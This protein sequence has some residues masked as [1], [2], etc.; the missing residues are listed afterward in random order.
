MR[1]SWVSFAVAACAIT[2]ASLAVYDLMP[3]RQ[4]S[5]WHRQGQAGAD[6][7]DLVDRAVPAADQ[8]PA[9]R[10]HAR[11]PVAKCDQFLPMRR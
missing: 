9:E 10:A 8:N 5:P 11:V 2:S 4:T 1:L 7:E 3:R 6:Q